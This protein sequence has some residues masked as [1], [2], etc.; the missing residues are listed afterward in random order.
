MNEKRVG[1]GA[2]RT[3]SLYHPKVTTPESSSSGL[4]YRVVCRFSTWVWSARDDDDAPRSSAGRPG[5]LRLRQ[6]STSTGKSARTCSGCGLAASACRKPCSLLARRCMNLIR[7]PCLRFRSVS[8]Q[9]S[10]VSPGPTP[11]EGGAPAADG[12]S[13]GG[14]SCL[15][16]AVFQRGRAARAPPGGRPACCSG[17]PADLN[18]HPTP[19]PPCLPLHYSCPRPGQRA[20]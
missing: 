10:V 20:L 15:S 9:S 11:T 12:R 13:A 5:L 18:S 7:V 4:Q 1:T 17:S 14:S 16:P 2:L 19:P 3:N 8:S 6:H